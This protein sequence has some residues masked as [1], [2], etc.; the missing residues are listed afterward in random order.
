MI[1]KR[2]NMNQFS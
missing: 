2:R 1:N